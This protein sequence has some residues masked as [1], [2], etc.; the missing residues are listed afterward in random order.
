MMLSGEGPS[1]A[2]LIKSSP[3]RWVIFA[4]DA[5]DSRAHVRARG[6]EPSVPRRLPSFSN[7]VSC[8]RHRSWPEPGDGPSGG[9]V[10]DIEGQDVPGVP[11][12][13]FSPGKR[14]LFS[15]G[16]ESPRQNS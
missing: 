6:L 16:R 7:A 2:A 15:R 4:S 13:L 8:F 1:P 3:E 9:V 11:A 10:T 14:V 5:D 12:H